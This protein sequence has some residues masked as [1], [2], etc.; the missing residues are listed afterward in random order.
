M[1]EWND[2]V[3][4]SYASY[5]DAFD[6]SD[7]FMELATKTAEA[8]FRRK[9]FESNITPDNVSEHNFHLVWLK[10]TAIL[11]GDPD[12]HPGPANRF[13]LEARFNADIP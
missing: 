2:L 3:R 8:V 4:K 12:Y 6:S 13:Y 11:Q 5:T 10:L 7:A 1:A 9:L